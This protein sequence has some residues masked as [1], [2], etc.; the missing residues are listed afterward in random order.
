MKLKQIKARI[1]QVN[2]DISCIGK[3][4]L[5]YRLKHEAYRKLGI[6][7]RIYPPR[8]ISDK[9]FFQQLDSGSL[10]IAPFSG[11]GEEL[12]KVLGN[13]FRNRE[14]VKF[15][16]DAQKLGDYNR[17]LNTRFEKDRQKVI[18]AADKICSHT[19]DCLEADTIHF[20]GKINWH[21]AFGNE[22]E[23]PGIHWSKL[24]IAPS[25]QW[26]DVRKTWEINRHQH[27][28]TLG[29]AYWYTGDNSYV[30]EFCA[31]I[32]NWIEENSL[33]IGVNWH[34]NLEIAV[35]S[36]AWIFALHFFETSSQL[37]DKLYF[38]TIKTLYHKGCHI[39]KYIDHTRHCM[40]GNHLIVEA[41][42]LV[43]IGMNF[44][45]F[46]ES[47]AWIEKGLRILFDE[48]DDQIYADGVNFE[49]SISYHR[50]VLD[51]YLLIALFCRLNNRPVPEKVWNKLE[52]MI[53]F[54][55]S[56]MRPDGSVPMIGDCDDAKVPLLSSDGIADYR[57]ALS[58]GAVLFQRPD[59]I[60]TANCL[61][62]ETLWLCGLEGIETFDSLHGENTEVVEQR[63]STA[64]KEGGYYVMRSS[65][66]EES[67]Y[68]LCKCGPFVKGHN[69]ADLLHIVVSSGQEDFLVDPGT[70]I[71]N[72]ERRWRDFFRSTLAHNTIAV[73]AESQRIPHRTFK[74]LGEASPKVH[75]W[76]STEE[77]DYL[78]AE[79]DGY[80][81]LNSPV[82]H[83][84]SILFAK[85]HY[86][87][88][89]DELA[90]RGEHKVE[91]FFHFPPSCQ[92]RL[93]D[94][95][96]T[97]L[98]RDE[99]T[100]RIVPLFAKGFEAI[101]QEHTE[102]PIQGWYSPRY[103][104]KLP[105]P[106]LIY[107]G[108]VDLPVQMVLLLLPLKQRNFNF[109]RATIEKFGSGEKGMDINVDCGSYVDNITFKSMEQP[110]FHRFY[111]SQ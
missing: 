70:Y 23:W 3:K 11:E 16:F 67:N 57:S 55:Q 64:F 63:T 34:S 76:M 69:H 25:E 95:V 68:L 65:S 91:S 94:N 60:Q 17:I 103:G 18:K 89:I 80:T 75:S 12:A 77:Y 33:E 92:Y 10:K 49:G 110:G 28:M 111:K 42:A 8:E 6:L 39:Y 4:E 99:E 101:V 1:L 7:E 53:E 36:I 105:S 46:R 29:R 85:P 61:S 102:E 97:L 83:R 74:W 78:W 22:P 35:R 96:F 47:E 98:N 73:D 45:E 37:D 50:F 56:V 109:C 51:S 38:Q 87:L 14:R 24:N 48:L 107:Q 19:F 106:T 20:R 90:G 30:Q 86:W 71:Y 40:K 54:I 15:F 59:F 9:D 66:G 41:A 79:H 108:K 88:L 93:D 5:L 100:F 31:Q 2:Q 84:R 52:K 21:H 13:H 81:R 32:R 44:Q 58:T 62:E 72:G 26:G 43:F 82:I 104:V 27:F